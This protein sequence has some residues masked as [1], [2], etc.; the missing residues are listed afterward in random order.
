[1][2]IALHPYI[3]G[4]PHRIHALEAAL[5]HIAKHDGVWWAT[6]TEIAEAYRKAAVLGERSRRG[7]FGGARDHRLRRGWA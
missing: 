4:V 1:M 2:A 7:R 5:D 3:T 6:G